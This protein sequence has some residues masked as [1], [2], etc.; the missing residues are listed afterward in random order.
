MIIEHMIYDL[1]KVLRNP[2]RKQMPEEDGNC[3]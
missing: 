1:R 2:P 3:G